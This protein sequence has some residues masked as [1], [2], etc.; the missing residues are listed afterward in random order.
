MCEVGVSRP[1]GATIVVEPPLPPVLVIVIVPPDAVRPIPAPFAST[2][3]CAAAFSGCLAETRT[4]W[5]LTY[6][7]PP[8]RPAVRGASNATNRFMPKRM[9][10]VSIAPP[11][12]Y[13][14]RHIIR[15][16]HMKLNVGLQSWR[17]VPLFQRLLLLAVAGCAQPA[18]TSAVAI[19]SISPSEARI[20]Y[21]DVP[22]G[23]YRIAVASYGTEPASPQTSTFPPGRK[24][25]SR[26]NR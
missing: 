3:S 20:W 17:L 1:C 22:P 8:A 23:H 4:S 18:L 26:S 6:I 11:G 14:A 24:L 16:R 21:R 7:P 25:T 19:P 9:S 5:R 12:P 15:E 2:V 10:L 13:L